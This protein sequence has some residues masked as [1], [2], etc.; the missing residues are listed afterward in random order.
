MMLYLASRFLMSG[1]DSVLTDFRKYPN[2][3]QGPSLRLE[4]LDAVDTGLVLTIWTTPCVR[5]FSSQSAKGY[6]ESAHSLRQMA[7]SFPEAPP[8]YKP[9]IVGLVVALKAIK[10]D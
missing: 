7:G 4:S 3:G 1:R 6:D 2:S 10:P 8:A 9:L 5:R